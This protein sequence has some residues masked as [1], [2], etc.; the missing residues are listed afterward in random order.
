MYRVYSVY[1]WD[2]ISQSQV[3]CTDENTTTIGDHLDCT[4]SKY[5]HP[6]REKRESLLLRCPIT[7]RRLPLLENRSFI[8]LGSQRRERRL[9]LFLTT[10][11][12]IGLA[13]KRRE[14]D[15]SEVIRYLGGLPCR[16]AEAWLHMAPVYWWW[17]GS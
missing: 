11:L 1:S 17:R 2:M 15:Q 3:L 12:C 4:G 16:R 8:R 10:S 13:R 6:E 14:G 9:P 7:R 5:G